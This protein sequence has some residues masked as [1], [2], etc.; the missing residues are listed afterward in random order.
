MTN[1]RVLWRFSELVSRQLYR[2]LEATAT[3]GLRS[4]VD[5]HRDQ[6]DVLDE[7]EHRRHTKLSS[8]YFSTSI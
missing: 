4:R 1:P 2:Q 3:D 8:F 7:I 5:V 6:V